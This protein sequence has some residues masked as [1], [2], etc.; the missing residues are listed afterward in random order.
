MNWNARRRKAGNGGNNYCRFMLINLCYFA[1]SFTRI[2]HMFAVV[3]PYL[4][5]GL[6]VQRQRRPRLTARMTMFR[7]SDGYM[8]ECNLYPE[9]RATTEGRKRV[10]DEG[11]IKGKARE[12]RARESA[13]G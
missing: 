7:W 2:H 8:R 3:M 5:V 11:V 1:A 6:L 4:R 13:L 12:G 9:I 10:D